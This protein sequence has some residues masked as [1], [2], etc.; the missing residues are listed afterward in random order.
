LWL[1]NQSPQLKLINIT[2]YPPE[3]NITLSYF[4]PRRA[5]S[6]PTGIRSST[7][8]KKKDGGDNIPAAKSALSQEWAVRKSRSAKGGDIN[9][10]APSPPCHKGDLRKSDGGDNI[11]ARL[12]GLIQECAVQKSRSKGGDIHIPAPP[13]PSEPSYP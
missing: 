4:E 8:L 11:T 5:M 6:P 2:Q 7:R 1:S 13:P 9:I 3:H 12:H 10:P